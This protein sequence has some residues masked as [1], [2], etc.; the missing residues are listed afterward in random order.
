VLNGEP[1]HDVEPFS[2]EDYDIV[3]THIG[4]M[5]LFL[6]LDLCSAEERFAERLF[7][8]ITWSNE[9]ADEVL[10]YVGGLSLFRELDMNTH[11]KLGESVDKAED[12]TNLIWVTPS[13]WNKV[14]GVT[15]LCGQSALPPGKSGFGGAS[16][17][18]EKG[19]TWGNNAFHP[20]NFATK[21]DRLSLNKIPAWQ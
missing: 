16:G 15:P 12:A 19:L 11:M 8:D 13:Q 2:K 10:T 20:E 1:R 7:G 21:Y 17:V 5:S 9:L 14:Y 6:E 3:M 18:F 4:G